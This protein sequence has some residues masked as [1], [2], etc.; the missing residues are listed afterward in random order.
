MKAPNKRRL[1]FETLRETIA[2]IPYFQPLLCARFAHDSDE[3]GD[4]FVDRS[5][6]HFAVIL[7]YLRTRQRPSEPILARQASALLDECAFY[8]L[9]PLTQKIKGELECSGGCSLVSP[10]NGPK[11]ETFTDFESTQRS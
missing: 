3:N 4:V 7:Q 9:D 2:E 10:E 8:G 5:G 11:N 1:Q 6:D